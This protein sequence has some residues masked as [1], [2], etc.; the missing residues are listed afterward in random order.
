MNWL[1]PKKSLKEIIGP[2]YVNFVSKLYL[3][4]EEKKKIFL[5]EGEKV[6]FLKK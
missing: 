1:T 5:K 6:E 2:F 3:M 4:N